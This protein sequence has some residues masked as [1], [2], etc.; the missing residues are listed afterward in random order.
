MNKENV[1]DQKTEIGT[2]ECLVE[3]VFLE[4]ITSAMKK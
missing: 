3:E 2:V 4:E 1:W